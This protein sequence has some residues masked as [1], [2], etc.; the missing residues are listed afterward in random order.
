MILGKRI[1]F[2]GIGR[3]DLPIFVAWMNDPDVRRGTSRY[4]PLSLGQE[5]A[6]YAEVLKR[7]AEEQP[8]GIEMRKGRGWLLIGT[9]S[10]FDINWQGRSAELGIMIGEKSE[11]NKGYGREAMWLMMQHG[12]ET[13]NLHRIVLHVYPENGGAVRVYEKIGF[14]HEGRLRD[15]HYAN[16]QYSDVLLMSMLRPEWDAVKSKD[17]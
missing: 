1:R 6:W 10:F 15:D 14:V 3:A 17:S 9:I 12:F 5:E 13:L 8:F 2:R 7:P 16:G 4:L 11:W